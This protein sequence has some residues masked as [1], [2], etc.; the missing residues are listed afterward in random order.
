[1]E[2][3][4]TDASCSLSV[5]LAGVLI[6][7]WIAA[8]RNQHLEWELVFPDDCEADEFRRNGVHLVVAPCPEIPVEIALFVRG[9]RCTEW[10]FFVLE[11]DGKGKE[12]Y[13]HYRDDDGT[14]RRW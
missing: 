12:D 6:G 8:V 7:G 3:Q 13:Y 10:R 11:D 1:M 14:Y 2:T 9:F 5:E 4:Q